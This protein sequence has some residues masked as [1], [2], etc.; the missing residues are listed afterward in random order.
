M[1]AS[2]LPPRSRESLE[3]LEAY[4]HSVLARPSPHLLAVACGAI[5]RGG[6]A[7]GSPFYGGA[8]V[9]RPTDEPR[10]EYDRQ[11]MLAMCREVIG[12]APGLRRFIVH[13]AR[14][15]TA[16]VWAVRHKLVPGIEVDAIAKKRGG[17]DKRVKAELASMRTPDVESVVFGRP[18]HSTEPVLWM[19]LD[20]GQRHL[21]PTPAL[22][23]LLA[24]S[25][26]LYRGAGHELVSATWSLDR[27]THL[28]FSDHFE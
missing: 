10:F 27:R 6:D 17:I 9:A 13:C 18:V 11:E 26:R 21:E 19:V 7:Y 22:L 12:E 28:E 16:A 14:E 25:D 15:S 4:V 24:E 20:T 3:R 1:D 23:Q 5:P 8:L 2:G